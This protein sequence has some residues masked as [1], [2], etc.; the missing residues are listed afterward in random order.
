MAEIC[1]F[2]TIFIL[3]RNI[4]GRVFGPVRFLIPVFQLYYILS[5]YRKFPSHLSK[6]YYSEDRTP[7][8]DPTLFG[9]TP[10]GMIS[11]K[12]GVKF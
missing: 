11:K 4:V 9:Y 8:D 7:D 10:F 1:Y 2:V 6:S 3:V 12:H 5:F